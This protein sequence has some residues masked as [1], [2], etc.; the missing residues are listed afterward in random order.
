MERAASSHGAHTRLRREMPTPVNF[1]RDAAF[2]VL[3][4]PAM[5]G[6]AALGAGIAAG[7]TIHARQGGDPLAC[8]PGSRQWLLCETS[9]TSGLPKTIRRN[10]ESWIRSFEVM[11]ERF[12]VSGADI[13]ATFGALGHS[14]TLYATLEAAHVGAGLLA[15]GMTGPRL[16][17]LTLAESRASVLYATPTQLGVLAS[18]A[19]AARIPAFPDARLVLIGGGA[20]VPRLRSELAA[21]FPRARLVEFFG[22]SETSFIAMSDADTPPGSVG[23]AYPGVRLRIDAEPGEP[24]EI[25]VNS[26]YLFDGYA[27]GDSDQTRWDGR[28]LSIGE[29]GHLDAGG[30]LFLKG[31]RN[32]MVTVADKNVFPEEIEAVVGRIEGVEA[33]AVVA[34]P[35]ARRGHAICC[36]VQAEPGKLS[37]AELR[38]R[39]RDLLGP[40]H[41]PR[42][43][44]FLPE[45]PLLASGKPDLRRLR[46]DPRL[47]P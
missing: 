33:C 47:P 41:V 28:F 16:Q 46:G 31:R 26:P 6:L 9:G 44:L 15:L 3:S 20:L 35:D 32:R 29:V 24:G 37:E 12:A 43:F 23:R 19:R 27:R 5:P 45:L 11:R 30:H 38:R 1:R 34:I 10:P 7:H 18:G 2:R 4:V 40:D 21:L 39:C 42:R 17:A 25:W 22:A 36:F 14:L 8:L 13:Y